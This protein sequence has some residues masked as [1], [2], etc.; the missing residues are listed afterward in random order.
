MYFPKYWAK[1]SHTG[2]T[3][4]G[5]QI[6]IEAYGWS[7]ESHED[8][9]ARGDER[10]KKVIEKG[11]S[12]KK[13]GDYEYGTAPFR[14]EVTDSLRV[15]DTDV[16]IISRNRYGALV[17]NS[18]QVMFVDI[19]TPEPRGIG[20]LDSI[21]MAF[22]GKRRREQA[23][24]KGLEILEA[25][26][27]WE[28]RNPSKSFRIYRTHSGFRLLFTD[29]LYDP[30]SAETKRILEELGADPLYRSLTE[31]QECFRARLTPKPWRCHSSRPPNHFPWEHPA[32]E[33]AHRRWEQGYHTACRDFATC[34]LVREI[35]TASNDPVIQAVLR[36]H[37]A[38]CLNESLPLA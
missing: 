35:G 9:R 12:S 6:T 36:A 16:A 4:D 11:F 19:D 14:E 7:S 22:S 30:G 5:R 27:A 10:A 23:E 15:N 28:L 38:A 20:I 33:E 37:D 24:A 25:V 18:A 31:R 1:G 17:L 32:E 8:A 34:Q 29:R 13:S 26:A 21:L 2:P 3:H